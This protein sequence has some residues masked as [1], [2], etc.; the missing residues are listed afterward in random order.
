MFSVIIPV[1][2]RVDLTEQ[3]F[4]CIS[5]NR[6]LPS[7]IILID[8]ASEEDFSHILKKHENLNIK[9]IRNDR[10]IGVNPAWNLGISLSKYKYVT[11]FNNDIII[12]TTFFDKLSIVFEHDKSVGIIVPNTVK[13]RNFNLEDKSNKIKV[14]N[15]GKREG[16]AFTIRKEILD[17]INPIPSCLITSCGDDY[18]FTYS[19]LNGYINVKIMN[20]FIYHYGSATVRI[21]L[22]NKR[23]EHSSTK[24]EREEWE[25]IKNQMYNK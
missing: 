4:N 22:E 9:Y 1:L 14:R 11:I 3:L 16:W 10:N 18:L 2:N 6:L 12:P 8:N 20:S 5:K 15:L 17:K 19:L 23:L 24:R 25:K 21:E 7:E 13:D